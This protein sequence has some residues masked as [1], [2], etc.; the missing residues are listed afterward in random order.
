MT[1][2]HRKLL[3]QI[4]LIGFIGTA[5]ALPSFVLAA[6]LYFKVVPSDISHDEAVIVEAYIDPEVQVLNAVD[7]IVHFEESAGVQI[8]SI[9]VETGGSLLSV[10]PLLPT[11]DE[12][13]STIRFTGGSRDGFDDE[14][15]LFRMRIFA[16]SPG[17]LRVSW[18]NTA[19]YRNDGKGTKENISARS[20]M[21][22]VTAGSPNLVNSAS[23][24]STPPV[25]AWIEIGRDPDTYDG[26]YFIN[27]LAT[28]DISGVSRYEVREGGEITEVLNGVYV[29][30]DQERKTQIHVT[31][32]DHAGNSKS[33]Q[34]PHM[35][36][37]TVNAIL[38]AIVVFT[39]LIFVGWYAYYKRH[40]GQI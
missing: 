5:L 21:L 38:I 8:S 13:E 10:W 37:W 33:V 12:K 7:G 22:S 29:L 27:F 9:V 18:L 30:K 11:Y 16:S 32:Y 3:V 20:L 2:L 19:V 23:V 28:D 39:L 36:Q 17:T 6:E 1:I 4:I 25:F 31:A 40:E 15:L 26:K 35:Y 34:V 24:D 14:G